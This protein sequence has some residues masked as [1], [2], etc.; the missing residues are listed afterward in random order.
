M[1]PLDLSA[2]ALAHRVRSGVV[3]PSEVAIAARARVAERNPA[4]N[5]MTVLN[6][7]LDEEAAEVARRLAAGEDLSLAGVP[8]VIKDNIWV[9]DLPIT[10][11]SRLFAEF[12]APKDAAA[13]SKLRDAG[14]M[15]LGIAT[16]SEFA[17]KGVTN[18]PL[19]GITRNPVD[20]RLT[21]GGSSG[22]PVAAVASG[23]A[24]LALGTDA[25]GS[26]RRPPAHT[27]LFGFK[28]TQDFVPYGPGFDEPVDGISVISPIARHLEDIDLAMQVLA[29]IS[30]GSVFAGTIAWSEDFGLGQKLDADVA[31]A[32]RGAVAQLKRQGFSLV[33]TAPDWGGL[34]G[35]S[36]MPLQFAGLARLF[37][38][39][40]K[41][42]RSVFDPDLALQI[43]TGL[44]L[45]AAEVANAKSASVHMGEI[46]NGFLE[47][48]DAVIVPT[49]PCPAW[50]VDRLA[51][52]F[53]GGL[54][55]APRDHAAFTPQA[56]H[57]G[58]PALSIPFAETKAGLPLGLQI[59]SAKG[60]DA[61]LLATAR[62]IMGALSRPKHERAS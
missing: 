19:H 35:G 31:L 30:T 3:T 34:T 29:G 45:T 58:C 37:G 59:I 40:L 62:N 39:A 38:E 42:D 56:N 9:K 55:C 8:V 16:C 1:N 41:E 6:P 17:C 44:G 27:G 20:T 5:A 21:P 32:L 12:V 43:E 47:G 36:V 46:L 51:P 11:G 28:P 52:E 14:A 25:G 10:Q 53:I 23:M 60:R 61:D 26:S 50:P 15:I 13:V 22:G 7:S 49:T 2:V 54:P 24:P 4:L 48:Y 57:A 33:E 18:T